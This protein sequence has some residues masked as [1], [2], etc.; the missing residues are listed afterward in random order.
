MSELYQQFIKD[1]PIYADQELIRKAFDVAVSAHEGQLRKSGE[2]YIIHPYHVVCILAEMQF[3]TVTICSGMLHDVPEDTDITL[4][5]VR[6]MFGGEVANIVDGVT[7]LSKLNFKSKEEAQAENFRKMFLAMA[8]DIRVIIVKLADRLHNMRTIEFQT[9]NKQVEK[10]Q[11]TIEIYAPLAHRLGMYVFEHEFEDI[12]LNVLHNEEYEAIK[13][14]RN[15]FASQRGADI[16]K[17]ISMVRDKVAEMGVKAEVYGRLKTIYSIYKKMETKNLDFAELYDLFAVRVIVDTVKDCYGVLGTLHA[18]WTPLPMRFKDY[19]AVPKENMYQSLHTTL[20]SKMGVPF[21]V[22]IRTH[23]MH[24][25]A[26]Y[27]IAAHWM[28]KEGG[29]TQDM[30]KKLEWLKEFME[31]QKEMKDSRE[32]M[33]TVKFNFFSDNVFVYTPKG[34]VKDFVKGSTPLDFAYSIHSAIG[35]KCIG[36]KINGRIVPLNYEMKTGDIVEI[37]TSSANKGPSRD[38]LNM[39]KTAQARA[40]IRAWFRKELKEDNIRKGREM[41]ERE[42]KRQGYDLYEL[43]KPE[44]LKPIFKRY[45]L[46]SNDDM[47]AAVGYGGLNT[48]QI[49]S[50]LIVEH[51]NANK[52]QIKEQEKVQKNKLRNNKSAVTVRGEADMAIRFG[53]CCNPIPGDDIIGYIT[54][55]RGVTVHRRDC[56]NVVNNSF[57]VTRQID[58]EWSNAGSS[59]STFLAELRIEC[60][61]KVGNIVEVSQIVYNLGFAIVSMNARALEKGYSSVIDL[62]IE[63]S[64]ARDIKSLIDKLM[65]LPSILNV[66][67]INNA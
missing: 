8:S 23:E 58:V 26:E 48:N 67:R 42:A 55:G 4:D 14:K 31:W 32:F 11:E 30:E 25:V 57:D 56:T 53:H 12:S 15:A 49:L 43:T 60:K 41:L 2:P 63:I 13:E 62:G 19:I 50:R 9:P 40:K 44:W 7:K 59:E 61:D 37:I 35:H 3:D 10:A 16:D 66:Y 54:R 1:Y 20:L 38:W 65:Q 17:I 64:S 33:E 39:V 28:Y 29:S 5:Q 45:T 51:K 27:G 18:E 34:D 46:N 6:E 24:R 52:I 21:E 36:A 47:F 22:Q